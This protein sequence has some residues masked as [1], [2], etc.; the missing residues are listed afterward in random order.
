VTVHHQ[1][2]VVFV[3]G[4]FRSKSDPYS[5]WEQAVN[6]QRAASVALE[7]WKLGAACICPHLNSAPFSGAASD[8]VWLD[9]C[10][11][12][13]ARCD[14]VMLTDDWASSSGAVAERDFALLHG[15]PVFH[16]LA[17]LQAWMSE[18]VP[19]LTCYQDNEGAERS[20]RGTMIGG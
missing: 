20:R 13:I 9:G 12:M 14:A 3:S 2:P 15:I 5:Q 16:H 19:P 1:Q 18:R 10:L 6:I 17:D 11:A 4:P 7:V 8:A